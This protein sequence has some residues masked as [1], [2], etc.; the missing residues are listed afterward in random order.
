MDDKEYTVDDINGLNEE[1]Q[2]AFNMLDF[3][4]RKLKE[5]KSMYRLIW[6]AHQNCSESLKKEIISDKAGFLFEED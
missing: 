2:I 6:G 3:T 5:L 4:D 1:A